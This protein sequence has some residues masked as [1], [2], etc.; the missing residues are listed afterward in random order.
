MPAQQ[1]QASLAAFVVGQQV[2]ETEHGGPIAR[3]ATGAALILGA[4]IAVYVLLLGDDG[5]TVKAR[6][7]AVS[8]LVPGNVVKIAGDRAG[9]IT[10][11]NLTRDGVAEVTFDLDRR[12]APLRSGTRAT[13][14]AQSLSGSASRYI[15]LRIPP[16]GGEPLRDGAVIDEASTSTDVDLDQFFSLFDDRTKKGLQ[17]M[18]RGSALQYGG[19]GAE[20]NAGWEYL[21][22][23]LLA[24]QRL[25]R[26]VNHDTPVLQDFLVS[27]SRLVGDIADRRDS[28]AGL[29]DRLATMTGAIARQER[30]LSDA[31]AQLPS[32]MRRA[33][34]TFVNLRATLD[35]LDGLVNDSK[36][37]AP[38]LRA[39]LAELRPFAREAT[40][41]VRS[42][43]DLVR[44]PGARN[45]LYELATSVPPL[46]D[47]AIGPVRRNG[48]ERPGA[49]PTA[50]ESLEGQTP[51][52]AFF[53][54]YA[55]DF[56]GWLDDFSHSG[57]H[58]ANGSA[59]RVATSVNAFAT[60][61]GTL[62]LIPPAL[63]QQV[64]AATTVQ[65]QNNRCPGATEHRYEDGSNPWKPAPGF[66]CDPSQTLPGD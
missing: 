26:E 38:R 54:P 1:A 20:A 17:N 55:V 49:F 51:H 32:F 62:K 8:V 35:D 39:V 22:P 33:N 37:V 11:I 58:D 29:I 7:R 13:I 3:I 59:S 19:R 15:D 24:A 57:I 64:T 14:R 52:F 56:T 12:F 63:R 41:T 2:G 66:N 9:T 28:L 42:L 60:V 45:D 43:A 21:N 46:R 31:I 23:S 40:P 48:K 36:P 47:I 5:Y 25:F 10:D 53:R 65:G 6:F 50:A 4:A 30:P 61:D 44:R 34:T 16:A 18:V 27:S